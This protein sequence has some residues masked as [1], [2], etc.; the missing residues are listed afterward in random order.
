MKSELVL[1][2][3]TFCI[4]KVNVFQ[5]ISSVKMEKLT[6]DQKFVFAKGSDLI[7]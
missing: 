5:M 3:K 7:I 1:K 6:K 2:L 4:L